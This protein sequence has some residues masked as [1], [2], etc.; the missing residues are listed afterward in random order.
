MLCHRI[1]AFKITKSGIQDLNLRPLRPE[2]SAL[3]NWANSRKK[4]RHTYWI[5]TVTLKAMHPEG[6]EPSTFWFVVRHSIQLRYGCKKSGRRDSNPRPPPWQ[7][8]VLPLN[9][10]RISLAI[11][12][13]STIINITWTI[14][15]CQHF[16]QIILMR[17]KGLEPLHQKIQDPK[18]CASANSATSAYGGYR[19]RTCDPLLVRQML[20][21]L[22]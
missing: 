12:L 18:S 13:L 3:P 17:M 5:V 11:Q 7:G 16:F 8:D 19:A 20:S 9:Y 4:K 1:T 15:N 14:V 21:Q 10:F 22:S 6:V 2:R